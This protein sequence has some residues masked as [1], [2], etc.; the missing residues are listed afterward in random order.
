[1]RGASVGCGRR[2]TLAAVSGAPEPD[3]EVELVDTGIDGRCATIGVVRVALS[4]SA[5]A[6]AATAAAA[7]AAV[8][9]VV[10]PLLLS[11]SPFTGV[12]SW[13][14]GGRGVNGGPDELKSPE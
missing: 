3:E 9:V 14:A 8:V 6:A 2:G 10:P 13:P 4:P 5:A 7:A 1:M 12:F 11:C